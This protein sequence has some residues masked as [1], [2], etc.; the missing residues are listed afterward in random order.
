MTLIEIDL[1]R[2]QK[3]ERS[4]LVKKKVTV[5]RNGKIFQRYQWVRPNKSVAANKKPE[6]SEG[7]KYAPTGNPEYDQKISKVLNDLD[8]RLEK[9]QNISQAVYEIIG[10][11]D[12][13]G[14]KYSLPPENSRLTESD[15]SNIKDDM[16]MIGRH[17]NG[18]LKDQIANVKIQRISRIVKEEEGDRSYHSGDVIV[19]SDKALENSVSERSRQRTLMHEYGHFIELW[20]PN[21]RDSCISFYTNRIKNE[22]IVKLNTLFPHNNY[23]DDEITCVDKF[24]E[25]YMGKLYSKDGSKENIRSTEL[26]SMGFEKMITEESKKEFYKKDKEHFG[27]ILAIMAGEIL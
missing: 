10:S 14:V 3:A 6:K 20:F 13:G 11:P 1:S 27:L 16:D 15:K 17:L 5:H 9:G 4:G 24:I 7:S 26:L 22:P 25:P 2:L 12:F 23:S 21:A 8:T 18:R 19:L